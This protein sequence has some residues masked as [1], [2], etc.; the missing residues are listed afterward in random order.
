MIS[1]RD[2]NDL[3]IETSK[4]CRQF[5]DECKKQKID[6]IITSTYRDIQ[7]QDN[8]YAQGRAIPGKIVTNARGGYSCH[9][10]GC[11]FDFCPIVNG[12]A[13]WNNLETF[14]KCGEIGKS[15]GLEWAGDW[16]SFKELA[17]FQ[18]TNGKTLAQL[19]E[20]K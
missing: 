7:S 12:K 18:Y 9:N 6:V 19:R 4:R 16:R 3:D 2:V 14:K 20:Q 8:L 17:H 10:F 15:L 13:Q 5:I 11:A 1:S